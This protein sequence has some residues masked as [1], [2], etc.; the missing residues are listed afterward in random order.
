M[1]KTKTKQAKSALPYLQRLLEDEDL[2]EQLR[3]AAGGLRGAYS[4]AR[5]R[6]TEEAVEDK[7]LWSNLR[8]S[9]VSIRDAALRIQPAK[10]EPKHR[11]R[12]ALS[13]ALAIGGCAWLT[14][15]LQKL[16]ARQER[17]TGGAPDG[18]TS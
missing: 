1:A 9:A 8:Q 5:S 16:Q 13:L 15:R 12:K 11:I 6:R 3:S 4:R 17:T 10:P 18:T 14:A 2:H 7:K